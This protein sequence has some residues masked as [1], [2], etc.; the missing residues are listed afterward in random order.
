MEYKRKSKTEDKKTARKTRQAYRKLDNENDE[1][2][3]ANKRNYSTI[4]SKKQFETTNSPDDS[5]EGSV[6]KK[7]HVKK[8]NRG[9][10][11]FNDPEV[12]VRQIR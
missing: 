7:K 12:I 11:T 1:I 10:T 9:N 6:K 3:K 4:Y 8:K 5:S 2:V